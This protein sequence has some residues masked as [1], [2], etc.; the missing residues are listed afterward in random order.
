MS[1]LTPSLS[2]S[3]LLCYFW[4]LGLNDIAYSSQ[5]MLAGLCGCGQ[6]HSY[7]SRLLSLP[8]HPPRILNEAFQITL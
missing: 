2:F 1:F 6:R 3:P 7:L 5:K 4:T 8:H